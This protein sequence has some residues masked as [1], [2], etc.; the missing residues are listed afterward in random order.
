MCQRICLSVCL[1]VTLCF[2]VFKHLPWL[3]PFAGGYEFTT[4]ILP[5]LNLVLNYWTHKVSIK[6]RRYQYIWIKYLIHDGGRSL[7][8]KKLLGPCMICN[9]IMLLCDSIRGKERKSKWTA[10]TATAATAAT[11]ISLVKI[12]SRL[13]A[14]VIKAYVSVLKAWRGVAQ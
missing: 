7:L 5:L 8:I 3:A 4:Q 13:R 6:N 12:R 9:M 14:A 2:F 10:S 11:S 1:A